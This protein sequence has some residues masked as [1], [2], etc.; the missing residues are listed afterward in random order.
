[1]MSLCDNSY[2]FFC[3]CWATL[4]FNLVLL[5]ALG[6]PFYNFKSSKLN[7]SASLFRQKIK[8]LLITLKTLVKAIFLPQ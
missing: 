5:L 8:K 1:M 6:W 7:K 3:L 2:D 4:F